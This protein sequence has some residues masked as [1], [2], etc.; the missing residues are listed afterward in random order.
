MNT[1]FV[2]VE[3]ECGRCSKTETVRARLNLESSMTTYHAEEIEI[4]ALL[5]IDRVPSVKTLLT[6]PRPEGWRTAPRYGTG[7]WVCKE[8][9]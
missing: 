6:V 2:M 1:L 7:A 8:C 3:V 5:E 9:T 4:S